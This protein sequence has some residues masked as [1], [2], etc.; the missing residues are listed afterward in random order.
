MACAT[1]AWTDPD[2]DPDP[3]ANHANAHAQAQG[4][5]D[6]AAQ[7]RGDPAAA[8]SPSPWHRQHPSPQHSRPGGR[9]DHT[10]R[11][12][13]ATRKQD[14]RSQPGRARPGDQEKDGRNGFRLPPTVRPATLA[15]A[16]REC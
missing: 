13:A 15:L 9:P 1:S 14:R 7:R 10:H 16:T 4:C 11:A 6:S 8:A 2:P 12:R 3:L 5:S